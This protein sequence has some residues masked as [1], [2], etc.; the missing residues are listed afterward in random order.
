MQVLLLTAPMTQL[1]A[2]YP[3][4]AYLT[5]YLRRHGIKTEQ[6]DASLELALRLFSRDGFMRLQ[7]E[8]VN[9][10]KV[11]SRSIKSPVV[12]FFL[13]NYPA[14]ACAID[15]TISFLQ[16]QNP[17]IAQRIVS[18]RFLP[19]GP[20]FNNLHTIE[21]TDDSALDW[22]FGNLGISDRARY[23]A[24][25][26]IDD[27]ADVVT[28]GIDPRFML[29]RYGESLASSEA[30]FKPIKDFLDAKPTLID[31]LIEDITKDFIDRHQ[32]TLIGIS[33]PFPGTVCG[34]FRIAK[35]VKSNYANIKTVLGG[36][37]VNTELR[38]FSEPQVF[39]YFDYV[40]LDDGEKPLQRI[41]ESLRKTKPSAKLLSTFVQR[42]GK[43]AFEGN[44]ENLP[45]S[46]E[47]CSPKPITYDGLPLT[48][49]LSI[50]EMLNPLH[51]LWSDTRWNKM[52]VAHGCYWKKCAFC[53]T[54]LDYIAN[55]K[56][57]AVGEIVDQIETLIRETG[58]NGFHFVDEAAPPALLSA[59]AKEL[60]KREVVISWWGNIRFER[61]FTTERVELLAESGCIAVTG[62]L[63][64][65]SDRTLKL[66]N[67]GYSVAEAARVM[68][69]FAAAGILV[70]SYLIYGFP[71][72]T[73][74]ETI[75]ALETIRQMFAAGC[76][77]S[78]YWHRFAL[79]AHSEMSRKPEKF[80]IH[81]TPLLDSPFARNEISYRE[82]PE[83]DHDLLGPGLQK[84]VYNYMHGVGLD[85]DV[86]SWFDFP[87][88]KTTVKKAYIEN[89]LL[90]SRRK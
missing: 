36:G 82:T 12:R 44:K 19:E 49:Y 65:C 59:M 62:G 73:H 84:A 30:T 60:L 16:G 46:K 34:A 35:T 11:N 23:L 81:L 29:A 53:D 55:Y 27:I 4:T 33:V 70:H 69:N 61:V 20:R 51:R 9:K 2:P 47:F 77:H 14:Y 17:S 5:G 72:Q 52:F 15:A 6:G 75:D 22:A 56:P 10:K 37:F 86:R 39:D 71:G 80:D 32:P 21:A 78:A 76:L 88:P 48:R 28:Y 50:C 85:A 41:V 1:N 54:T 90:G 45:D 58:Q 63:E 24:S 18:R 83:I 74:T 43:V 13:E 67:K 26:F 38:F 89:L 87:V 68:H 64:T 66:M 7:N 40:T 31:L 79:T 42:Q 8:L 57:L 3:A 25:L